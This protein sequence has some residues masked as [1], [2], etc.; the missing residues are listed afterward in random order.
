[1]KN[2]MGKTQLDEWNKNAA[3]HM[4]RANIAGYLGVFFFVAFIFVH[5]WGVW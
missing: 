3:K 4:R 2:H 1:M 5:L